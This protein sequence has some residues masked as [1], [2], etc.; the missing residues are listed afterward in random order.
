ME[1]GKRLAELLDGVEVLER[2]GSLSV[3]IRGIAY[4]SRDVGPGYLFAAFPG[5]HTDGHR[6]IADA[7][8]RGAAAVL[9]SRE[10]GFHDP[11]AAC[12]RVADTRRALSP[13]AASFHGHPSRRLAVLGVTGTDGKSTTVWL[14]HQLL[15]ALG[16]RCG[17]ISTV[18]VNAEGRAEKTPLRQSTPEAPEIHGLLRRMLDA[19]RRFAVVEATS[20]GLSERTCRLADV[21]FDVAVLTNVTHEHLEFHG[22]LE[23]YRSDKANLFRA[24]SRGPAKRGVRRFGVVNL[25]DPHHTYFRA[26]T[27]APVASYGRE[28]D[29]P[30]PGEPPGGAPN[31]ASRGRAS[32][33]GGI[34]PAGA[35]LWAAGLAADA[36][37]TSLVLRTPTEAQPVRLNL[38][39]RVNVEN[40]LAAA[41]AVSRLLDVPLRALAPHVPGLRPVRGRREPVEMGQ[42]FR[43]YVDYA[44]TPGAFEKVLPDFRRETPGALVAVFGSAGERDTAKRPRL[45]E[46]ASRF[47]DRIILA[48]EDPR[49]EDGLEILR[50][51]AAGCP[52]R[53]EGGGPQIVP[54]RREAIRAAFAAARPGDTVLLLGKGHEGS[55][56]YARGPMEWDEAEEARR[57]LRELGYRG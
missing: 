54:D 25:N 32:P 6:Y 27:A 47:C 19:G 40:L 34:P 13:I 23:Q 7:L 35:D 26:Q 28:G 4:D 2:R 8:R 53:K 16:E 46:A 10:L 52:S 51:I 1:A 12:I 14:I 31:E 18:E 44:H 20:H 39:G 29:L 45:G 56:V 43:V 21:A 57:A 30:P 5:Q 55:I 36:A 41:L 24:L 33:G 37:G 9:H 11:G 49:G 3:R 38:P 48:D 42:P 22:T 15:E 50:Q 17:F